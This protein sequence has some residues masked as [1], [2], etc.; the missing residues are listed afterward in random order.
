MQPVRAF[1]VTAAVALV[2][3]GCGSGDGKKAGAD[4]TPTARTGPGA[5]KPPVVLGT[6]N[7]TEQFILG[8]LY[9]QALRA[10][11]WKVQ[12]KDNIGST[13]IADQALT[14]G[15]I[16]LYPEYTGTTLSVIKGDTGRTTSA[17]RT[18]REA[19]AFYERRGQTLLRPTPF[20]NRDTLAVTKRFS[21]A[22]GG[23]KSPRDLKRLGSSVRL[24]A[25][26]EFR[27]R[28][29]GLEGLRSEYG[30]T[31]AEFV[32]IEIGM[33]YKELDAGRI[34][35]AD[36][37][38]TD[39]QLASGD[40]VALSDPEAIFGF[41]NVAPVVDREVLADQGGAFAD[42][43][44]AVSGKLTNKAMRRM[45]GAVSLEHRSAASV[46]RAFLKRNALL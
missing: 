43:L 5:D 22:N 44:D 1:L 17:Q 11:G 36:V 37:F 13:E 30:L 12:L 35:A 3:S 29:A 7:F 23:L 31:K 40:Y 2:V 28:F 45:N 15:G 6:K 27:T 18:Y 8:Q 14:R 9:A 33:A 46:A 16:D 26:P 4:A 41:Q 38:S 19:K 32:P 42:T 39:G 21:Q 34:Q 20:E 24:G 25:A 10:K